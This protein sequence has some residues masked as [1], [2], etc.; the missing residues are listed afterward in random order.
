MVTDAT[1]AEPPAAYTAL[2]DEINRYN[3]VESAT[4]V[5]SWDQQVMMPEGGTPARST[6]LSTLS[7]ISHE[8]LVDGDVGNHLD[9]LDDASLTPEQQA[10]VREIRREYVRA[11]RVP[12][13]LIE[14]IS[15]ATTEALGA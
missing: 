5:L 7:S 13:D 12:R 1:Q 11:A 2:L 9:E 15:T 4:E 10:V 3:A 6:Q 14:E 8:L